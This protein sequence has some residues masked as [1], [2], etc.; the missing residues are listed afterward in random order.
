MLVV[1]SVSPQCLMQAELAARIHSGW[2][3]SVCMCLCNR[4]MAEWLRRQAAHRRDPGS[5]PAQAWTYISPELIGIGS[6]LYLFQHLTLPTSYFILLNH[7]I[8]LK[9]LDPLDLQKQ[10][11]YFTPNTKRYG[12]TG[13]RYWWV[14]ACLTKM[15]LLINWVLHLGNL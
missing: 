6:G 14:Y 4:P 12:G 7:E 3:C 10:G 2:E 1:S 5:N 15:N 9:N 11:M 13:Q 8:N